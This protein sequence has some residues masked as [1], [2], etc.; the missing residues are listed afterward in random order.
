MD[1]MVRVAESRAIN[2]RLGAI[3]KRRFSQALDR[4]EVPT[5]DWF[6][7]K[8]NNEIYHYDAGNFEAY[9]VTG[10]GTFHLHHSLKAIPADATQILVQKEEGYWKIKHYIKWYY[11]DQHRSLYHRGEGKMVQYQ[12]STDGTYE[13]YMESPT[14]KDARAVSVTPDG[15]G[16]KV[17]QKYDFSADI[18]SDVTSQEEIESQIMAR[19]KRHLQHTAREGGITTGKLMHEIQ[20]NHGLNPRADDLL[21]GRFETEHEAS[22]EMSTRIQAVNQTDKERDT[23][24][25]VRVMT[26][27]FQYAIKIANEKTSSSL[28]GMHYTMWKVMAASDFCV[29]FLCI[30]ISLPFMCGFANDQ[31]LQ[32]IYVMLEKKKGGRKIYLLRIIGLLEAEFNTT[33]IFFFANQMIIIVEENGLSDEQHGLRKN[34]TCTDAAMI[35]LLT[36]ECT[37]AKKSTIGEVSHDCKACFNRIEHLQSNRLVQK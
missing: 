13:E 36:F 8:K 14:P 16:Y 31:W 10:L 24:K 27:Q 26:K 3:T 11:S 15:V 9:P 29:E 34:R 30:M 18:W 20:A 28:S 25:V 12:R 7:S 4:I 5:Q 22:E 21:L 1:Q 2:R 33:L 23:L 35:K 19:N 37:R 32:E 17:V 6:H